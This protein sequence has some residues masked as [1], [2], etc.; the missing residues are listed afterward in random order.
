MWTRPDPQKLH[1]KYVAHGLNAK[2]KDDCSKLSCVTF[3]TD[4]P[5]R[6]TASQA[7]HG[8]TWPCR[9]VHE[10][11]SACW[12]RFDACFFQT[13]ALVSRSA[14]FRSREASPPRD[15]Q[16]RPVCMGLQAY[17][18]AFWNQSD[19][20]VSAQDPRF[21]EWFENPGSL[22]MQT[23][24]DQVMVLPFAAAVLGL[25]PG[26]LGGVRVLLAEI[27]ALHTR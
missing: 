27:W 25:L 3:R 9:Q 20:D 11:P 5:Y 15:S 22:I 4:I 7:T 21:W 26:V 6:H 18:E 17:V 16:R 8:A 2:Y 23:Q 13:A 19:K 1:A 12:C 24:T 14:A 10:C